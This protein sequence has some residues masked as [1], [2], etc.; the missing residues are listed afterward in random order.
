[1][2]VVACGIANVGRVILQLSIAILQEEGVKEFL[3]VWSIPKSATI[4]AT[5]LAYRGSTRED[6][7]FTQKLIH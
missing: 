7:L 1:M 3:L 6:L 2:V 5:M 4:H